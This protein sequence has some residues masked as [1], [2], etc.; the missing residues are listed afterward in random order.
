MSIY[1]HSRR[2]ARCLASRRTAA[3][4]AATSKQRLQYITTSLLSPRGCVRTSDSEQLSEMRTFHAHTC[5]FHGYLRPGTHARSAK[6]CD[7]GRGVYLHALLYRRARA[8]RNISV[9]AHLCT[10][11]PHPQA[12]FVTWCY[13]TR[14]KYAQTSIMA[15]YR[16]HFDHHRTDILAIQ[17][18]WLFDRLLSSIYHS[19]DGAVVASTTA[20]SL[21]ESS[22][23]MTND[24]VRVNKFILDTSWLPGFARA[25]P[26]LLLPPHSLLLSTLPPS[27]YPASPRIFAV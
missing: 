13:I 1:T 22:T 2:V 5:N 27:D 3:A 9:C 7:V 23:A 25:S 12:V 4:K 11:K 20:K 24:V 26:S 15:W 14:V 8:R 18:I 6:T 19:L 16:P 17:N 21:I 10:L